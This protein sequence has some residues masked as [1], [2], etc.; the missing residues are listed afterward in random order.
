MNRPSR[1]RSSGSM[2]RRF[3]P[4]NSTS[5]SVTSKA[6]RPARTPAKVLLP[7]PFGPMMACTS[8]AF[9]VRSMPRSISLSSTR[10]WRLEILSISSLAPTEVPSV[11]LGSISKPTD[12]LPW[13]GSLPDTSLEAHPEQLLRFDREL[14]RQLAEHFLAESVDDH[15]DRVFRGQAALFA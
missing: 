7:E 14:H 4:S 15:V 3:L 5:P 13:G 9:S 10:A 1:A 6:S 2:S 8:L 11:G 12:G